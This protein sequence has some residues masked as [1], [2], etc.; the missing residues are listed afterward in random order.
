M[1]GAIIRNSQ[2]PICKMCKHIRFDTQ[3]PD[4]YKLAKCVKFGHQC[5]VSGEVTH[6]FAERCRR[7]SLQCGEEGKHFEKK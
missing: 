5:L 2:Y 4:E 7:D 3:Y 6:L 1:I